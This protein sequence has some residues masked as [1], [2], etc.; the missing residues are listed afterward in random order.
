MK[1]KWSV[2]TKWFHFWFRWCFELSYESCGYF[3][4]R[5]RINIGLIFFHMTFVLPIKSKHTDE[6]DPPQWGIAIHNNT[7]WIYRGGEGNMKG[8]NKWWT[9]NM[10]WSWE[11]VRTSI[12]AV[13]GKSWY[14]D[15]PKTPQEFYEPRWKAKIWRER[16]PYHYVMGDGAQYCYATIK[17]EEREWRW[18]WLRWLPFPRKVV[19]QIDVS[20]SKEMGPEAGS[21]KGGVTGC[22]WEMRKG[23]TPKQCLD[24]MEREIKF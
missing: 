16:H 11:W 9:F 22:G 2:E 4:P 10:P 8:G 21:W 7:F 23:E 1:S 3:D 5:H 14:H 12:L 20:F 6:C 19:R 24:R 17:V 13:D 18:N 15:T